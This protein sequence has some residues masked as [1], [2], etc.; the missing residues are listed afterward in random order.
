MT[1]FHSE[2]LLAQALRHLLY[3]GHT[4]EVARVLNETH[5]QD[6]LS[7]SQ[8]S[9]MSLLDMALRMGDQDTFLQLVDR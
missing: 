7:L 5:V 1:T 8:E 4:R 9:Q 3:A 6:A 2:R